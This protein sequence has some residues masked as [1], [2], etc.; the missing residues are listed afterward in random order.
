MPKRR[1][2]EL[3]ESQRVELERARDQHATA[4]MREKAGALQK[5][6]AGQSAHAVAETG[7]LKRRGSGT[8]Y[9]WL[10]RFEA[11]GLSGLEVRAGRGRKP[12]FSP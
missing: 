9:A 7:L 11:E 4:Y 1:Y 12:A 10:D 8:L 6:A 5:I 3:N 2:L